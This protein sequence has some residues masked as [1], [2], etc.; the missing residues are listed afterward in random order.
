M[1]TIPQIG[2]PTYPSSPDPTNPSTGTNSLSRS[3]CTTTTVTDCS[4]NCNSNNPQSTQSCAT[5]CSLISGCNVTATTTTTTGVC[6]GSYPTI[7]VWDTGMLPVST[8]GAITSTG[9]Y[10]SSSPLSSTATALPSSTSTGPYTGE[11][12]PA[13]FQTAEWALNL[14]A[15]SNCGAGSFLKGYYEHK[16]KYSCIAVPPGAQSWQFVS[17]DP[18]CGN[19]L[20]NPCFPEAT[21]F[22]GSNNQCLTQGS[23]VISQGCGA[24]LGCQNSCNGLCPI[25][26]I[27]GLIRPGCQGGRLSISPKKKRSLGAPKDDIAGSPQEE[28]TEE[29]GNNTIKSALH[30][31][32]KRAY[33]GPK[34]GPAN[35]DGPCST[36][37]CLPTRELHLRQGIQESNTTFYSLDELEK[38]ALGS[39]IPLV[40]YLGSKQ[41]IDLYSN[42]PEDPSLSWLERKSSTGADVT[43]MNQSPFKNIPFKI[44]M[45]SYRSGSGYEFF[46]LSGCTILAIVSDQA[47][48]MVRAYTKLSR[49]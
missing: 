27:S 7:S 36:N 6:T 39:C 35:A 1:L 2:D 49:C 17:A 38:R 44:G 14:Y 26:A 41:L 15:D 13:T 22:G 42:T 16:V 31:L 9:T 37:G 46:Y 24:N 47:V 34:C 23:T 4:V 19:E 43:Y 28:Y 25:V 10:P 5:S 29:I 12:T 18:N 30:F 45:G 20:S 32:A 8:S 33:T 21:L 48:Y 11:S 40:T 3:S